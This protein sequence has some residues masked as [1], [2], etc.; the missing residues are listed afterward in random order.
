MSITPEIRFLRYVEGI[1]DP[2][3][4]WF[5]NGSLDPN[6]YGL[7]VV[8]GKKYKAHRFAW[9]YEFG[10]DLDAS[11]QLL[12][13]CESFACVNP[14][15]WMRSTPENRFWEKVDKSGP[16]M[17][18]M[19]TNCWLWVGSIGLDG[20]GTF[21]YSSRYKKA[22]AVSYILNIGPIPRY[23]HICHACD[24]RACVRP[25]HLWLGTPKENT[26]D[27]IAKGRARGGAKVP[28]KGME[29]ESQAKLTDDDVRQIRRIYD[30]KT[31][32]Q[33]ALAQQ[34]GVSQSL[35]NGILKGK[36]WAHLL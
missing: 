23:K 13:R 3:G 34:F 15:H 1:E 8:E 19:E 33:Y 28:L 18:H 2:D 35:I 24:N 21:Y 31:F 36:R 6:G 17:P 27:M 26:Q 30:K 12:S 32:N 29:K 14:Y 20:Y 9:L 4:C 16:T 10:E 25:D 7:F 11:Q 5:W 22:H